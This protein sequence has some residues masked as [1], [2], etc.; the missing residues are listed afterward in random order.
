[1]DDVCLLRITHT[2]LQGRSASVWITNEVGQRP[3][4]GTR[5]KLFH[6]LHTDGQVEGVKATLSTSRVSSALE[7]SGFFAEHGTGLFAC[8]SHRLE[9]RLI[10]GR[11]RRGLWRY[12]GLCAL[13]FGALC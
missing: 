3:I 12:N 13:I 6:L 5:E 4:R 10:C 7:W 2:I 9:E 8:R 11:R 1:S